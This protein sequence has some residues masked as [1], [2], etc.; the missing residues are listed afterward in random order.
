MRQ[1]TDAYDEDFIPVF[2]WA[3]IETG[4]VTAEIDGFA[5]DN[6]DS[7]VEIIKVMERKVYDNTAKNIALK[8]GMNKQIVPVLFNKDSIR[9]L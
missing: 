6:F 4:F 5:M 1:G 9:I 2:S 3:S 7:I 8:C